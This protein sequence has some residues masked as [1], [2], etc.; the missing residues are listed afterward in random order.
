MSRC[1]WT[2]CRPV[3]SSTLIREECDGVDVQLNANM[4]HRDREWRISN[5][6]FPYHL[7]L[8]HVGDIVNP[9]LLVSV[10]SFNPVYEV[11]HE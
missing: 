8:G 6:Y 9:E 10:H 2:R 1:D 3:A 11:S 7:V 4:K 5:Y